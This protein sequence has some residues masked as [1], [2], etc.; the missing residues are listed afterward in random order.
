MHRSFAIAAACCLIATS[1]QASRSCLNKNQA[2]RTW[3]TKQLVKDDDGCWTFR[4]V[5]QQEQVRPD[6][7]RA[8]A[9]VTILRVIR[10]T[11]E[12]EKAWS[13]RWPDVEITPR[14]P[15]FVEPQQ[16]MMTARN[17]VS[18]VL[19]V[20]L[21]VALAEVSLGLTRWNS[22]KIDRKHPE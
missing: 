2:A 18:V 21:V 6:A 11:P 12:G 13:D 14:Q 9:P 5:P 1:A 20:A 15:V 4:R 22:I 8:D 3:P 17:V 10:A 16:P 19:V 7:T